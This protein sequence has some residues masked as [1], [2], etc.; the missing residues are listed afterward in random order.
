MERS[1]RTTAFDVLARTARALM[2]TQ[3]KAET[4]RSASIDPRLLSD[5]LLRDL[6][7]LDGPPERPLQAEAQAECRM[8][9]FAGLWITPR[10][11]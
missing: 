6:G 11:S 1:L 3:S 8:S 9:A 7:L 10:A 2:A 5:H 4:Y